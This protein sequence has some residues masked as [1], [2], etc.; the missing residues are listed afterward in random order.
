MTVQETQTQVSIRP[1]SDSH[2]NDEKTWKSLLLR[3]GYKQ[4]KATRS[5]S[6]TSKKKRKEQREQE[7]KKKEEPHLHRRLPPRSKRVVPAQLEER[8]EEE[9]EPFDSPLPDF[10]GPFDLPVF[11]DE[12]EEETSS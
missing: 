5:S 1:W 2:T 8:E 3:S 9:E 11:M 10:D 12:E 7:E 4:P 6:T